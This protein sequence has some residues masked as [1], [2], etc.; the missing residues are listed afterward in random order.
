MTF[1]S[2]L[3]S[4]FITPLTLIFELI[5]GLSYSA[6]PNPAVNLIILSLSFNFLVLPLYRRAD[7]LQMEARKTEE[8][9]R[10]VTNH[11][12][13]SFK[14]DE[15][16]M[17]LQAYYKLVNY[18]PLSSLKS[19]TSL[20]LQI[21]FFIAA[22]RFLSKLPLLEGQSMGPVKNL[23]EPDGLLVI[24]GF[25]INILPIIMTVVNVA[26]SE[27][28][29]KGQPFKNKIVL[30]ISALVFLVLL[31]NS[32]SGLVFYWTLNNVFS[33]FKNI[34]YKMFDRR[35]EK[36]K[37]EQRQLKKGEQL[38]FWTSAIFMAAFVG[39]LIPSSVVSSSPMDFIFVNDVKN[40]SHYVWYT[41]AVALGFY[42]IWIGVYYLLGSSR[43]RRIF[44]MALF[45]LAGTSAFNYFVYGSGLGT[46]T[47]EL[48]FD[49]DITLDTGLMLITTLSS[50]I[51]FAAFFMLS[52]YLKNV[53]KYIV[54][55]G[56]L[57]V[58]GMGISNIVDI[59]RVYADSS[60]SENTVTEGSFTLSRTGRNVMVI[61]LDRAI[62]SYVPFI[63]NEDSDLVRQFDGFTYYPNTISYGQYTNFGAPALF[64]GYEYT[65]ENINKRSDELLV[66]KH[67]EALLVMPLVFDD[68]GYDVTV[69]DPPYANYRE[70]PDT[71][72]FDGYDVDAFVSEP[73]LNEHYGEMNS[74]LENA[75]FHNFF[76][77][78][79]LKI[80]PTIVQSVIYNGGS[81][82]YLTD[83]VITSEEGS[84]HFPQSYETASK[85]KGINPDFYSGYEVLDGLFSI[86]DITD[87]ESNNLLIMKNLT[88][89]SPNILQT[90]GY[91]ISDSV[92]NTDYDNEHYG[93]SLP[94]GRTI[95]L[96]AY[97][98]MAHY[99]ANMSA[100]KLLGKW[101][102][103]LRENGV[104]DNTRIIVV[105]DHGRSLFQDTRLI[106]DDLM[107]DAQ[108]V[109][110]VLMVK[111]FYST[112]FATSDEFMT[113]ADV[114]TLAMDGLIEDPVNPFTGSPIDNSSKL[115]GPQHIIVSD[116]WRVQENDG[117]TFLPGSWYSV[118]N[119]I[120]ERENWVYLGDY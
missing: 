94:D 12:K 48:I 97:V 75:R 84:F 13:S 42:L 11:I 96:D 68:A 63:F 101:F 5:F 38:L 30:Y 32:P 110:P 118:S 92:D 17:I 58:T 35:P 119:N 106:F 62:G 76:A 23:M 39:F 71:S 69:I 3:E 80:S 109:N 65:P 54:V 7:I 14:G 70:V 120:F 103:Q 87:K 81:Y 61:M 21:P 98:Q 105:S 77:Y 108:S 107:L 33:L 88:A 55:A 28:F 99:H 57:A 82:N 64:G 16:V 40:P 6:V 2:V 31:Y 49:F 90:P 34:V 79:M 112:G 25:A 43:T 46:I 9:I 117:N 67:N 19:I 29:S 27:I 104:W 93:R 78:S 44:G 37:T 24:G 102:D 114:P 51:V 115:S 36:K 89:H 45:A 66:N 59:N 91:T 10:P 73:V 4:L 85:T 15:R 116:H 53:S 22:Y 100:M 60:P 41:L 113:N 26:S 83:N 20:L 52:K 8:E 95:V 86:T 72:I 50:V 1:F 47:T 18:N 74:F 56:L 111:D